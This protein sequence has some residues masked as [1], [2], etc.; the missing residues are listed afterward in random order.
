MLKHVVIGLFLATLPGCTV[1]PA[2][3][4]FLA[5]SV[6]RPKYPYVRP[7]PFKMAT[8]KLE[9]DDRV[10]PTVAQRRLK[11]GDPIGSRRTRAACCSP[12]PA[13]SA[14]RFNSWADTHGLGPTAVRMN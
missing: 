13:T 3:R 2:P 8:Y 1:S 14:F 11:Y 12:W 4:V 7:V 6:K 10:Q 9:R 5:A